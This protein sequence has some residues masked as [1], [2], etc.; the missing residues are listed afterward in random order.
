MP[1]PRSDLRSEGRC[2]IDT[3]IK[4]LPFEHSYL[5]LSHIEPTPSF[6]S[7]VKLEAI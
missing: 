2:V 1:L 7:V 5:N 6:W 3:A 4:T